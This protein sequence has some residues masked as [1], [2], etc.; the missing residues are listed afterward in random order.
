[1]K[2]HETTKQPQN[3]KNT[4]EQ[5]NYRTVK[6]STQ[7]EHSKCKYIHITKTHTYITKHMKLKQ[8]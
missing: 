6:I 7:T 2:I 5:N 3:I 4:K 1:M 8:T